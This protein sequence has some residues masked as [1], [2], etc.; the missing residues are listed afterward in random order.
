MRWLYLH[1]PQ[2]QLDAMERPESGQACIIV[3]PKDYTVCQPDPLARQHGITKGMGLGTATAL[4]HPLSIL[5]L[6]PEFEAQ[7]LQELA[8]SFYQFTADIAV[9]EPDGLLF[10]VSSMLAL[11]GSLEH[12]LQCVRTLLTQQDVTA[13]LA[14]ANTSLAAR[15]LARHAATRTTP[16]DASVVTEAEAVDTLLSRLPLHALELPVRQC[17]QL[18]RIGLNRLSDLE[19]LSRKELGIR[20]G[21]TLLKTLDQIRGRHP[22]PLSFFKPTP[23]FSR[24]LLLEHEIQRSDA[25]LFPVQKL[26]QQ[27]QQFL[28][29]G[30][31]Q[32]QG[33]RLILGFRDQSEH[34]IELNSAEP[35][36]TWTVWRQ[37]LQLKL[38]ALRLKAPVI[39]LRVESGPLLDAQAHC[40][41][42]FSVQPPRSP[43]QVVS[44]LQAK[45]GR[46]SLHR[47]QLHED[48]RP[49][50]A[51]SYEAIDHHRSRATDSRTPGTSLRPNLLLE[52]PERL[53]ETIRILHGP[54]RIQ[55][56]W[57]TDEKICRD[58]FVATNTRGQ[59]LWVFR[60]RQQNWF[61]HGLF[62]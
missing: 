62:A 41:D 40:P 48:Y 32:V 23:A 53:S 22:T 15:L 58:Y 49:E 5:T 27:L 33:L 37:L 42:L 39:K 43:G 13:H 6:N 10:E 18:R 61:V 26:L 60:D 51:F 50:H 59:T 11:H 4:C 30:A 17:E 16:T 29:S 28:Q 34:G 9:F 14:M 2:L 55:S 54:E 46:E 21:S 1:F 47:I 35:E 31:L 3:H 52:Q 19:A 25:L 57:W 44:R 8:D 45:I 36:Q 24:S 20:G 7:R 56:A 38:E 12:Y